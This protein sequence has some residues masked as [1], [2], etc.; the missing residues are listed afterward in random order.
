MAQPAPGD[1]RYATAHRPWQLGA[2]LVRRSVFDRVGV[3]DARLRRAVDADWFMRVREAGIRCR[4]IDA[5]TV[6]YH[7]HASNLSR[8]VAASRSDLLLALKD[9]IGRRRTGR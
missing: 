3:F 5:V 2:S 8:D 6:R 9:A 7:L 1:P 4:Q